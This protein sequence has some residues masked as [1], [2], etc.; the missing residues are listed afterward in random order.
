[1]A[2]DV[3]GAVLEDWLGDRSSNAMETESDVTLEKLIVNDLVK[4]AIDC[5]VA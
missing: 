4:K 1:M 2:A 5:Y 3:R